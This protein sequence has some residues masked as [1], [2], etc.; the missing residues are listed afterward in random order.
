[1][2]N[3][4]HSLIGLDRTAQAWIM[5]DLRFDRS[6]TP[7]MFTLILPEPRPTPVSCPQTAPWSMPRAGLL[8]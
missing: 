5:G 3:V 2:D 6:P 8:R 7:G 1:V 4:T